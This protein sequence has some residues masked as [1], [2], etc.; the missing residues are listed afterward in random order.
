MLL[1]YA[2]SDC[3]NTMLSSCLL[4]GPG[5]ELHALP[6]FRRNATITRKLNLKLSK[7]VVF[8]FVLGIVFIQL[9]IAVLKGQKTSNKAWRNKFI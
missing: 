4:K 2:A 3:R 1:Q 7:R 5:N 8:V 6:N 9:F